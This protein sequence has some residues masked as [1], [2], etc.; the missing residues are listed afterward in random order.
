MKILI[1]SLP[2]TGSSSLMK[3]YSEEY[4][5]KSVFEPFDPRQKDKYD[6]KLDD[7]VLKT[8]IYHKPKGFDDPIVGHTE[9]SKEFDKIILL[10]RRDLKEC[11]ESWAYLKQHNRK[12]FN[13]TKHYIWTT[14]P[15]IENHF[16]DIQKWHNDLEKLSEILNIEITYYEDIFD[17][18]SNERYRKNISIKDKKL[19]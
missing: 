7:I 6:S 5:L 11:A 1:I 12:N 13:A 9:L 8:I 17:K 2:R 16:L 15:D 3:K 4:K 14:P 18:N 10:S 19:I